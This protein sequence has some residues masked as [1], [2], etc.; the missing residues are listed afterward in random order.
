MRWAKGVP[1]VLPPWSETYD[2]RV[3][4][5]TIRCSRY[6]GCGTR[7]MKTVLVAS[8]LASLMTKDLPWALGEPCACVM[9][10]DVSKFVGLLIEAIRT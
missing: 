8:D 9:M 5:P 3:P 10:H 4:D 1:S 7:R 2:I 6:V